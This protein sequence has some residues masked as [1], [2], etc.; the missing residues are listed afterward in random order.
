LYKKR[1][2]GFFCICGHELLYVSCVVE[3]YDLEFIS[4]YTNQNMRFEK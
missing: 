4:T 1:R 3:I 2:M